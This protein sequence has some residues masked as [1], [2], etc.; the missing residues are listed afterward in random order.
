MP[1]E[2]LQSEISNFKS[3]ISNSP[4]PFD[5][6]TSPDYEWSAPTNL[7]S[8]VNSAAG[9]GSPCLSADGLTLLFDSDRPGGQGKADLWMSGRPTLTAPWSA[10][11]NLGAT[12]NSSENEKVPTLS[13]DGLALVFAS[14][15]GQ[16]DKRYKLWWCHRQTTAEPWSTPTRQQLEVTVAPGVSDY[17]PE[18]SA[19]GLSLLFTS[20]PRAGTHGLEDLWQCRRPTTTDPWGPVQNLGAFVNGPAKDMDPALSSDGRVLVFASDR[21]GGLGKIDFWWSSRPSLVAPWSAPQNLSK[22]VNSEIDELSPTLSADG[23]MLLFRSNR[24]GGRGGND[25]WSSHRVRKK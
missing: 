21:P 9:E 8:V 16:S 19:D 3:E 2:I 6:L 14:D 20:F 17:E 12:V 13:S 24:P 10:P 23:Q 25:I 1:P 18:L 4:S 11:E 7:G 5:I 22:P 15:R